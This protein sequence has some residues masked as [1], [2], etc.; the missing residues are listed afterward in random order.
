MDVQSI[1][2]NTVLSDS[3]IMVYGIH[4][5]EDRY[6]RIFAQENFDD[7]LGIEGSVSG[8][9]VPCLRSKIREDDQPGVLAM[10]NLK[11]STAALIPGGSL[12]YAFRNKDGIWFRM[13]VIP[14]EF[15]DQT[16][17]R[18]VLTV[19]SIRRENE[20]EQAYR[21][22]LQNALDENQRLKFIDELTGYCNKKGFYRQVKAVMSANPEQQY[23]L[24]YSDIA[25][26]GY[27]N[28]V[29]GYDVGN[30]LLQY[31]TAAMKARLQDSDVLGRIT[32]DYFAILFC[33]NSPQRQAE[34]ER[35]C[36]EVLDQ[37][38][39]YFKRFDRNHQLE[40]YSGIY[41]VMPEEVGTITVDQMITRASI[42]QKIA[43][44][45]QQDPVAFFNAGQW[46]LHRRALE[47]AAGLSKAIADGEI[48]VWLQ[49]Q[50]DYFTHRIV[51]AEALSRWKSA[52]L[53]WIAPGEFVPVL[54]SSGQIGELDAYVWDKA[55]A[56]AR[57]LMDDPKCISLPLSIN[58]SRRD[59]RSLDVVA[60]LKELLD[61]YQL[62]P[63][64]IHLEI[65]ES[66]YIE[67]PESLIVLVQ[68]L[69]ALGFAVEMDDFGSGYSS[70]SMLKELP[71]DTLK[72]DLLFLAEGNQER[73][74]GNIISSVIRM[75]QGLN[76]SV[77]AEGV[78]T[79][80]QAEALKNMGCNIMQGYFFSKPIPPSEFWKLPALH[81]EQT[82]PT[83]GGSEI[84][85][86][87]NCLYDI[88]N[89]GTR[90]SYIFNHFSSATAILELS[91]GRVE[92]MSVNDEFLQVVGDRGGKV[93]LNMKNGLVLIR[94][95]SRPRVLLTLEKAV[96]EGRAACEVYF[97]GTS[98]WVRLTCRHI[99]STP[100]ADYLFCE[101]ANTSQEHR[102]ST[103]VNNLIEESHTEF[104]MMP[105]GAFR[106]AAD[107]AQEF[108]YVS[109][110]T[111]ELL[112]F[113]T[114]E[115]FLETYP[116][117]PDLVYA[118]DRA[119]VLREIDEQ[120]A[121]N[122]CKDYCEYR[123]R[124]GDGRLMWVYDHGRLVT[125]AD[126][127]KW[128][129]V[130]IADLD[131]VM[132]ERRERDLQATKYQNLTLTPGVNV[133]EYDI[134]R[135]RM[136]MNLTQPS[137][138]KQTLV[139]KDYLKQM[140]QMG[141]AT[142]DTAELVRPAFQQAMEKP[143]SGTINYY[144]RF[145]S[146][147]IQ[148][149]HF[150]YTSIQGKDGRINT[151]IGSAA[152]V[153]SHPSAEP[154]GA[155]DEQAGLMSYQTA[156]NR[157]QE[158]LLQTPGGA[159]MM[160]DLNDFKERGDSPTQPHG[161]AFLKALASALLQAFRPGDVVGRFGGCEI[162]VFLPGMTDADHVRARSDALMAALRDSKIFAE[163]PIHIGVAVAGTQM[164]AAED[165]LH[166]ADLELSKAEQTDEDQCSIALL[167][168]QGGRPDAPSPEGVPAAVQ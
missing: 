36:Q 89:T 131:Q 76:L 35:I 81:M 71:V 109:S 166:Q 7:L 118:E 86:K 75:A 63:A 3:Y 137:G 59:Q 9:L 117:F 54:E 164:V 102:L 21:H 64:Q 112:H 133:F 158:L 58:I 18:V 107:G 150:C 154:N 30:E 138:E 139:L 48:E 96:Q 151:I 147:R 136:T 78:E 24:C 127:K 104:N 19:E 38:N 98:Q 60:T 37:V 134:G 161:E 141:W 32:G 93:R 152:S 168:E 39:R 149:Y 85:E 142:M 23:A 100:S 5:A 4:L 8:G 92:I 162:V 56:L 122:G 87:L 97:D 50:Y 52:S 14:A 123:I 46:K 110:G 11:Q 31:W 49:P 62:P 42:A 91:N 145:G 41:V 105:A 128:F 80:E 113:P 125:D 47:I 17:T 33:L 153:E 83:D 163:H 140:E 74:G 53:G 148:Q 132:Q 111:L 124:T 67:E 44:S 43:K 6:E 114:L 108:A 57:K 45:S 70:L 120:I 126:G 27:V 69:Q 160:L 130:V 2:I 12:N 101:A 135:D 129:Y 95:S 28:S 119:R 51:G 90:S 1:F 155:W 68:N 82:V 121:R 94:E 157:I 116:T 99:F 77:I 65:T 22:R 73:K 165:L 55:F 40:I 84:D 167:K 115:T 16:L 20:L 15:E 106:Y 72:M 79:E 159:L 26:L 146:Q 66:A 103:Q 34:V 13:R 156:I 10:L 143:S 61:K 88:L 25:N 29:W 144:G